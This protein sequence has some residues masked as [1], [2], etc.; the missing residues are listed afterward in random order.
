MAADLILERFERVDTSATTALL[1]V[2]GVWRRPPGPVPGLRV[3]DR[4]VRALP[5]PRA[6]D[7]AAG[8]WRTGYPAPVALLAGA[9]SF[10]LVLGDGSA[11]ALPRPAAPGEPL[12]SAEALGVGGLVERLRA[13]LAEAARRADA[14]R[15]ELAGARE[16]GAAAETEL[17]ARLGEA[18]A[19]RSEAESVLIILGAKLDRARDAGERAAAE[20]DEAAARAAELEARLA[21]LQAG[22]GARRRPW[23]RGRRR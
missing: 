1:R 11:I 10:A 4:V 13:E 6:G 5:G 17:R 16:A 3:G 22:V 15:S 8:A 12:P 23:E 2:E 9:P 19:A 20:R 7:V 21:T 18:E 14:L